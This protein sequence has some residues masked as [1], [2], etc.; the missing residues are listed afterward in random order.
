MAANVASSINLLEYPA[1]AIAL[2]NEEQCALGLVA[3]QVTLG[4]PRGMEG[5]VQW[6]PT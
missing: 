1:H 3:Q 5:P 2:S 4:A 6:E